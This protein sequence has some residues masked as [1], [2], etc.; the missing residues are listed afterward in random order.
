[1]HALTSWIPERISI[2]PNS[3][4]FNKDKVFDKIHDRYHKGD[5]LVTVA[6]GQLSQSDQDR[7]GLVECHA[8]A[9]LDVRQVLVKCILS[10]KKK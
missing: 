3:A 2:R 7:A 6:T 9:M 10:L 1:M 8:Y 4:D 5:C